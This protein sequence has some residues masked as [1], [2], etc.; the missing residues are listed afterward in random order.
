MQAS[1]GHRPPTCFLQG[2]C[3]P[4]TCSDSV[5]QELTGLEL[6]L[7]RVSKPSAFLL[8]RTRSP[9][10][11]RISQLLRLSLPKAPVAYRHRRLKEWQLEG[12][13][14]VSLPF[15]CQRMAQIQHQM[16]LRF[17]GTWRKSLCFSSALE[18]WFNTRNRT[19]AHNSRWFKG[20]LW[21]DLV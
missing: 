6:P 21:T 9:A 10:L 17:M 4:R 1:G 8:R 2:T 13:E 7:G 19:N 18:K 11:L 14:E 16:G 5:W 15:K 3:K 12:P 20:G